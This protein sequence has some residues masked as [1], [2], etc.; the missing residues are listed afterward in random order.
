MFKSATRYD[1]GIALVITVICAKMV[2]KDILG[3]QMDLDRVLFSFL[4]IPIFI[5]VF[6][7][8]ARCSIS[9]LLHLILNI[10]H[11]EK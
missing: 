4:T 1:A 3:L 8:L 10:V 2:G 11:K 9:L 7:Y 6:Y 5:I